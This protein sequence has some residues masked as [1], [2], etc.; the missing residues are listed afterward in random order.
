MYIPSLHLSTN[1]AIRH[2]G[3]V[4]LGTSWSPVNPSRVTL[5][6]QCP[7]LRNCTVTAAAAPLCPP[8]RMP[9]T[10]ICAFSPPSLSAPSTPPPP[11]PTPRRVQHCSY[12]IQAGRSCSPPPLRRWKGLEG[13]ATAGNTQMKIWTPYTEQVL[14][15]NSCSNAVSVTS[16]CFIYKE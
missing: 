6:V 4:T 9:L 1:V 16:Q 2:P 5:A 11:S 7:L 14:L 3:L 13:S 15:S 10:C 8:L 12:S